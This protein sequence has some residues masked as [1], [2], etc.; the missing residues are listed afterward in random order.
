MNLA[1]CNKLEQGIQRLCFPA[2]Y[3]WLQ[4]AACSIKKKCMYVP[5]QENNTSDNKIPAARKLIF[6]EQVEK[7]LQNTNKETAIKHSNM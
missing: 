4:R 6:E 7:K 1:L 3:F 5:V 2:S